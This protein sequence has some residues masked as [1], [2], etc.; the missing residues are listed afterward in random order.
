MLLLVFR[1]PGGFVM[2]HMRN[3]T[4]K[5]RRLKGKGKTVA[6]K[7]IFMCRKDC[8]ICKLPLPGVI[9]AYLSWPV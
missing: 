7:A 8:V 3:D 1:S 5:H 2:K 6:T 9:K 4:T